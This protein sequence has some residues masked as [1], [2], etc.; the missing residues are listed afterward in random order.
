LSFVPVLS[1]AQTKPVAQTERQI[2]KIDS[3]VREKMKS[4]N[5]PGLS[6]AVVREGKIVLAKGYG[7]ANL[8]LSTPANEKTCFLL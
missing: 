2:E 4:K 7:M 6:L 5:I 1:W 3:F 8:E